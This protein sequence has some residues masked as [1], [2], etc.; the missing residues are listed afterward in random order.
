MKRLL[1]K[2]G[3]LFK[4]YVISLIS[5]KLLDRP[6]ILDQTAYALEIQISRG[7][8]PRS[9]NSHPALISLSK[10][11]LTWLLEKNKE[12]MP[13]RLSLAKR[14]Q[15]VNNVIEVRNAIA[16]YKRSESAKTERWL[17]CWSWR[18]WMSVS[19]QHITRPCVSSQA[20]KATPPAPLKFLQASAWPL[21]RWQ[22]AAS[23]HCLS[24]MA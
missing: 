10:G 7:I 18:A 21:E 8:L 12:Y 15:A 3:S 14:R 20:N 9:A 22:W 6:R 13:A 24:W 4:L 1:I 11:V 23:W 5:K 19:I 16:M 2:P 17:A